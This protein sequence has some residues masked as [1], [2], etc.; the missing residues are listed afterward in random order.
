MSGAITFCL[1]K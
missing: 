1:F